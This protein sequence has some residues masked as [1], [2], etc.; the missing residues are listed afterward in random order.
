MLL[1]YCNFYLFCYSLFDFF[2]ALKIR[3]LYKRFKN[4][5]FALLLWFLTII[6]VSRLP[7][8]GRCVSN[9]WLLRELESSACLSD[10]I[11][12]HEWV[13]LQ[14]ILCQSSWHCTTI[15]WCSDWHQQ[16]NRYITRNIQSFI[17]WCYCSKSCKYYFT[18]PKS[19]IIFSLLLK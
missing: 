3:F 2:A 1:T 18:F 12:W 16:Y 14:W 4:A 5:L 9:R 19:M 6:L 17:D 8:P 7:I 15:C 10:H 13:C 11:C